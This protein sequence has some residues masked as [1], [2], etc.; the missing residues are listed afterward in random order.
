MLTIRNALV[1][2]DIAQKDLA[3]IGRNV[4]LWWDAVH[5]GKEL[6]RVPQSHDGIN[7]EVWEYPDWAK[8]DI[9][10]IAARYCNRHGVSFVR[11]K[12]KRK[13]IKL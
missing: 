2:Y 6:G 1:R 4:K 8:K 10:K 5:K 7:Y 9:I 13:K 11:Q 12:R 3:T